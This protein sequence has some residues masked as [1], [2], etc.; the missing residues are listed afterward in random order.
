[1]LSVV[2]LLALSACTPPGIPSRVLLIQAGGI[3]PKEDARLLRQIDHKLEEFGFLA[4][5]SL[6]PLEAVDVDA[7][8]KQAR[9]DQAAHAIVMHLETAEERPGALDGTS[10]Y[11]VRATA[12]I[13]NTDPVH[14]ETEPLVLEFAHEDTSAGALA[15]GVLD[16]WTKVFPPHIADVVAHS[17]QMELVFSGEAD[18]RF[19]AAGAKLRPYEDFLHARRELVDA[20]DSYCRSEG[21]RIQRFAEAEGVT[22]VGNPCGQYA[23]VGVTPEGR[24]V[25]EDLSRVPFFSV[26]VDSSAQWIEPP[27]RLFVLEADGSER[28]LM[29]SDNFYGIATLRAGDTITAE[30]FT[31]EGH[32]ALWGVSATDGSPKKRVLLGP[33]ERNTISEVS[34][35]G[36]TAFFCLRG[37]GGCFVQGDGERAEIPDLSWGRW[38]T[39]D[40]GLRLVGELR[41]EEGIVIVDPANPSAPIRARG[42]AKGR[43][44]EVVGASAGQVSVISRTGRD[45]ALEHLDVGS[46]KVLS[47]AALPACIDSASLLADGRLVGTAVATGPNDVPGDVEVVVWAPG[48]DAPTPLTVGSFYEEIVY[49]SPDG[50]TVFFNRRLEAPPDTRV[51]TRVYRRSVCSVPLPPR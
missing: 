27:E 24:P 46:G 45:C 42:R 1:M 3:E 50:S 30:T 14:A 41:D 47:S 26:P 7:A 20:Y 38:V 48:D 22:C 12:H 15:S 5:V 39:P 43:L 13:I 21:E 29:R 10:L 28:R 49:P 16:T 33:G 17:R 36:S 2:S 32:S 31:S 8:R 18:T 9:A 11:V 4:N 51:D 19:I 23:L 40:A 35:D 44:H 6:E 37:G 34:P 25:A